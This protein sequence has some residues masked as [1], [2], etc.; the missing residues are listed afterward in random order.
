MSRSIL[1]NREAYPNLAGNLIQSATH[2]EYTAYS[3]QGLRKRHNADNQQ[4]FHC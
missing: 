2:V 1:L 4:T 3:K